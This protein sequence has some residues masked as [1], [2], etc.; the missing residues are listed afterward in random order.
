[1]APSQQGRGHGRRLMGHAE[2]LARDAQRKELRLVTNAAFA[3][4]VALYRST[5]Y[6]V[7]R[8]EPFMG[9]VALYMS[10]PLA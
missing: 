3:R 8:T 4:N 6:V 7:T 9:G 2:T 10:K 5:G 1:M